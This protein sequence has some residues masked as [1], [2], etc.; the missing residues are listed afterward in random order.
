MRAW[1]ATATALTLSALT[2]LSTVLTP[3]AVL[4]D[5]PPSNNPCRVKIIE[6]S[7][8][9]MVSP[10]ESDADPNGYRASVSYNHA[11][12]VK[13]QVKARFAKFFPEKPIDIEIIPL[14]KTN[15]GVEELS[16]RLSSETPF[17]A[18]I[19][20]TAILSFTIY[21]YD[22]YIKERLPSYN[23]KIT[24]GNLLY[25]ASF[26]QNAL[27]RP[28]EGETEESVKR[29]ESFRTASNFINNLAGRSLVFKAAG[30]FG[31]IFIDPHS[32]RKNILNVVAEDEYGKLTPYSNAR[33]PGITVGDSGDV[34]VSGV[35]I[36]ENKVILENGLVLT[37][38]LIKENP[39]GSVKRKPL[40]RLLQIED[41]QRWIGKV[42]AQGTS[43]AAPLQVG[44]AAAFC[45]KTLREHPE[46]PPLPLLQQVRED[47]LGDFWTR[48]RQ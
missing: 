14:P 37:I 47:I 11:E 41:A 23:Q 30:N 6:P 8:P 4:A 42:V 9:E 44:T 48:R 10:L 43:F 1:S 27:A 17:I 28:V 2:T 29:K 31:N 12:M 36:S 25:F 20:A 38:K 3:A 13:A 40:N 46:I 26:L 18:N 15:K 35:N 24:T 22:F 45:E 21:E 39:D 34:H 32:I 33:I 16:K 7:L 5:T 19:S